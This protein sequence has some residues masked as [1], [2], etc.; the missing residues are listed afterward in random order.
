MRRITAVLAS[1]ILL[2]AACGGDDDSD[3]GSPQDAA[4]QT[5]IDQ[6]NT[7]D[8][9]PD[10]DCI[11]DKASALSDEDAQK[12][13]DQGDQVADLS[14]EGMAIQTEALTCLSGEAMLDQIVEELPEGI[15]G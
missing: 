13:V 15:D 9:N 7:D 2:L 11:R 10:E 1:S 8:L 6:A 3:S 14:P 5:L 12:I 4:A